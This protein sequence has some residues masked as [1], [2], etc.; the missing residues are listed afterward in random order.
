M[1]IPHSPHATHPLVPSEVYWHG[2]RG[3][4]PKPKGKTTEF[5]TGGPSRLTQ[6]GSPKVLVARVTSG[7]GTKAPHL[8]YLHMLMGPMATPGTGGPDVP[9]PWVTSL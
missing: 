4:L 9:L 5:I 7:L 8:T 3:G 1:V 2:A 6:V